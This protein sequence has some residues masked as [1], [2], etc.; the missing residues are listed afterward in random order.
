MRFFACDHPTDSSRNITTSIKTISSVQRL[1]ET[2]YTAVH[3]SVTA[4]VAFIVTSAL[5][6]T[7]IHLADTNEL[8]NHKSGETKMSLHFTEGHKN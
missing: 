2:I 6:L 4:G 3:Y 8:K 5:M 1:L 7:E